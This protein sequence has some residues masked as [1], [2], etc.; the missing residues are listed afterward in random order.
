MRA[1]LILA[2]TPL[3]ACVAPAPAEAPVAAANAPLR[4]MRADG[5]PFGFEEGA[6]ARG[7]ADQLC[8]G[9][10]RTS[11][12]DRYEAGAWVFVGGCA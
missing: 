5:G 12:Y 4:V 6:V 11:I 7:Q 3:A 2:C 10:V 1:A 9:K 8:G